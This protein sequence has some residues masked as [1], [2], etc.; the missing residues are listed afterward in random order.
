MAFGLIDRFTGYTLRHL[1]DIERAYAAPASDRAST[2]AWR[3]STV[4]AA[5]RPAYAQVLG[6]DPPTS[7]EPADWPILR[8][9]EA[10][11]IAAAA[12][13]RSTS[14]H[15]IVTTSGSG[16]VPLQLPLSAFRHARQ[17]AELLYYTGW[18]GY[19]VGDPHAYVSISGAKTRV[20]AWMQNEQHLHAD[21]IGLD[22]CDEALK[23]LRGR[24]YR[25]LI[26]YP[27]TLELLAATATNNGRH[28]TFDVDAV[29]TIGEPLKPST[30]ATLDAVFGGPTVS[31]Y[32]ARELGV[33][34][35]ECERQQFHVNSATFDFELID[36]S[37]QPVTEPGDSG[38]VVVTD[39]FARQVPL[40]RYELGDIATWGTPCDCGR[41][42][43]TLE[44]IDGRSTDT[45]ETT[46]GKPI[47]GF[48]INSA[49][50]NVRTIHQFQFQQR[51]DGYRILVVPSKNGDDARHDLDAATGDLKSVLGADAAIEVEFVEV[52]PADPS[53]K[54]PNVK[55][56]RSDTARASQT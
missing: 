24:H 35:H 8:K 26:G 47:S 11:A 39:L 5:A 23:K 41:P 30:R 25:A 20:T 16:G 50:R 54:R 19:R 46:D 32:A 55:D 9:T 36:P 12:Q 14:P 29:V 43:P 44:R 31:R 48:R 34:A 13:A 38:R 27:S 45:L 56:L 53:G 22:W 7:D 51:D 42:G 1:H 6:W 52:V 28:R 21:T 10:R 17:H 18:F 3:R 40:V 2:T 4:M 37:G 33:I 49:F 15:K